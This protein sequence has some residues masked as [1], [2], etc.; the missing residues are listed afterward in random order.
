MRLLPGNGR[1]TCGVAWVRI[2]LGRGSDAR[3]GVDRI[4]RESPGGDRIP[5]KQATFLSI[6][7]SGLASGLACYAA[8]P[9]S[10]G[11]DEFRWVFD[12]VLGDA[13]LF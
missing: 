7:L 1:R 5:P 8:P 13:F 4:D 2:G 9:G 11:D 10:F 12:N 6:A 3:V